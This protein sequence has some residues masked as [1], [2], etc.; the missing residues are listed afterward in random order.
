MK[1]GKDA[2][3][4]NWVCDE[5]DNQASLNQIF[6]IGNLL[7]CFLWGLANDRCKKNKTTKSVVNWT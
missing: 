6:W 3:Q 1:G 5:D 4:R 2:L 7:G